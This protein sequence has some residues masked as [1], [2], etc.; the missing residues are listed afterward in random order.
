MSTPLCA[1][2][3]SPTPHVVL[4]PRP[5]EEETGPRP[6]LPFCFWCALNIQAFLTRVLTDFQ[7]SEEK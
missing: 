6:P 5:G 1:L 3:E 4:I 7:C 2:C